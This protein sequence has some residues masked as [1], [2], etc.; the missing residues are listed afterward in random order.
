MSTV[1]IDT[2]V[3]YMYLF[4]YVYYYE[5]HASVDIANQRSVVSVQ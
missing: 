2:I 3:K 5:S 1:Y 4:M